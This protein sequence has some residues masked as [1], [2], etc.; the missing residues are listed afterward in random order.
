M[1]CWHGCLVAKVEGV[2]VW[3]ERVGGE[4]SGI[5]CWVVVGFVELGVLTD[6]VV[7]EIGFVVV[8]VADLIIV[9]VI[10]KSFN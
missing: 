9:D 10:G 5:N 8:W 2:V 4:D 7:A 6:L 1:V 3:L